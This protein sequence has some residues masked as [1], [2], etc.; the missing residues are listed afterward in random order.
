MKMH[1]LTSLSAALLIC[2]LTLSVVADESRPASPAESSELVWHSSIEAGLQNAQRTKQPVLV[3]V[4]AEWCGWCKKLD[5]EIKKPAVQTKLKDWT[6]VRLDA[7]KDTAAVRKLAVGPIPALR[8]LSASGRTVASHDGFLDGDALIK[9]LDESYKRALA[10]SQVLMNEPKS[11][12]DAQVLI[13]LLIDQDALVREAAI[14]LLLRRPELAAPKAIDAFAKGT[15]AGRL[16]VLEL[17][18]DWKAPLDGMD[19][20]HPASIT[21]QRLEA[22][23]NWA[24]HAKPRSPTTVP[25]TRPSST[26]PALEAAAAESLTPDVRASA[27]RDIALLLAAESAMEQRAVRERLARVGPALLPD[28]SSALMA[29]SSDEERVRL[30]TLRYRLAA[31][32]K[33]AASWPEGLERLADLNA[34]TRHRAVDELASKVTADDGALLL[35]LFADTDPLVR[36]TSLRLL[37]STGGQIGVANLVRLLQDPEPNV[38]AAVLKQ[39]AEVPARGL[40]A[41][42]IK[43]VQGEKDADLIVHAVRVLRGSKTK[44]SASTL[45]TLLTHESWRVRAEAAEALGKLLENTGNNRDVVISLEQRAD[46]NSAMIKLLEDPDAFVVSRAVL[47]LRDANVVA[48]MEPLVEAATRRPELAPDVVRALS[49]GGASGASLKFLQKF[50]GHADPLV[51]AA[52]IHGLVTAAPMSA[53][54]EI[55]AAIKDPVPA[56]R[57]AAVTALVDAMERGRPNP[58]EEV[59]TGFFGFGGTKKPRDMEAW[60]KSFRSGGRPTWMSQFTEPLEIMLAGAAPGATSAETVAVAVPLTA[61]GQD[62]KALPVLTAAAA[63]ADPA[64]RRAAARALPWLPWEQREPLFKALLAK[65]EGDELAAHLHELI[66]IPN[67]AAANVLW[68]TLSSPAA[69]AKLA[70]EVRDSLKRAYLGSRYYDSNTVTDPKRQALVLAAKAKLSDGSDLHRLVAMALLVEQSPK[71]VIGPAEQLSKERPVGDPLKLDAF[72]VL[73]LA[74]KQASAKDADVDALAALTGD[75][76]H[77]MKKIALKFLCLNGT[78]LTFL[79]NVI[80]ISASFRGEMVISGSKESVT[81]KPPEGLKLET[82]R[83]MLNDEDKPI[84]ACAGYLACLFGDRSGLDPLLAHWRSNPADHEWR[85]LAYRAITALGDENLTPVLEEVYNSMGDQKAYSAREFYWTIRDLK[86]EKITQLRKRVRDDV[87]AQQLQ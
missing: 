20:W 29:T 40:D 49:Q 42:V 51:R 18:T 55:N 7:D 63:M 74:K 45:M 44:A 13:D 58:E 14:H 81:I 78:E 53:A 1:F 35:E 77:E 84:A 11:P 19:P 39:L 87:G 75:A 34:E 65:A 32:S 57:L 80:W 12:A 73:L 28:V 59:S 79:R 61:L 16:A 24:A 72:Q 3:D 46:I 2:L 5:E 82:I 60:V 64:S 15:L 38:R 27:R 54:T 25:T 9:W 76:P 33:L 83:P 30:K 47:V 66:K 8:I 68:D 26:R 36:E 85:R 31:S 69:D 50:C 10:A 21:P 22:L 37:Q 71:D 4:G 23:K 17:L 86:G 70:G 6:L 48:A 41:E 56:V 43:F 62:A 67:P 52:A